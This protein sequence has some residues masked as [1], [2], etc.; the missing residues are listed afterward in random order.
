MPLTYKQPQLNYDQGYGA[1]NHSW[2]VLEVT[3]PDGIAVGKV[4]EKVYEAL[5]TFEWFN[6]YP[7]NKTAMMFPESSPLDGTK[8][9]RFEARGMWGKAAAFWNGHW[10][11]VRIWSRRSSYLVTGDTADTHMLVGQRRWWCLLKDSR[12]LVVRTESY[13][14]PRGK[15]NWVG[16]RLS[17]KKNQ[18]E[19]WRWYLQNIAFHLEHDK[20]KLAS[21]E[22]DSAKKPDDNLWPPVNPYP[23]VEIP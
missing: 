15:V 23:G 22:G 2:H 6:A 4:V 10:V 17:G 1:V 18:L 7:H 13:D 11:P 21:L 5:K 8:F 20:G 3:F 9:I 14:Q 19:V 16:F 12:T